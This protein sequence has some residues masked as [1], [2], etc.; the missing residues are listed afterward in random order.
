[1]EDEEAEVVCCTMSPNVGE[2]NVS[3]GD[4]HGGQ[5]SSTRPPPQKL[6]STSL[7]PCN[8]GVRGFGFSRR[9]GD[10]PK[11]FMFSLLD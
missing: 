3:G 6:F 2:I 10:F 8:N 7:Y 5:K 11:F 1:M 4:D 9:R